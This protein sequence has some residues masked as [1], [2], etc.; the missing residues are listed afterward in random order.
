MEI[1]LGNLP[2]E[3]DEQTVRDTFAE[4]GTFFRIA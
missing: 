3:T 1:Y 4:Y 2:Y